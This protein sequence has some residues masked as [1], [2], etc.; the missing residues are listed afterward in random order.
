MGA[1]TDPPITDEVLLKQLPGMIEIDPALRA[2]AARGLCALVEKVEGWKQADVREAM[3]GI[4]L[5]ERDD[6]FMNLVSKADCL[7]NAAAMGLDQDEID[8]LTGPPTPGFLDVM[9]SV[10]GVRVCFGLPVAVVWLKLDHAVV[11]GEGN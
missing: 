10:G 11:N 7:A 5:A 6:V 2:Q 4:V 1:K 8:T 9:L 3:V